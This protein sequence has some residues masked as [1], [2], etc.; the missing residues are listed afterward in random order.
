MVHTGS[1]I[2]ELEEGE[3]EESDDRFAHNDNV[4][5]NNIID[6]NALTSLSGDQDQ[7]NV[8]EDDDEEEEDAF[9]E[10]GEY[11]KLG[12]NTDTE[13]QVS[14]DFMFEKNMEYLFKPS[15]QD[16]DYT[17]SGLTVLF[18]EQSVTDNPF[19]IEYGKLVNNYMLLLLVINLL[20]RQRRSNSI[21]N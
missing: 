10:N 9:D 18:N 16:T 8:E 19:A 4:S 13:N 11:R 1:T 14:K 6:T 2:L 3:D 21:K 7:T 15:H 12:N 20:E 17:M 5:T